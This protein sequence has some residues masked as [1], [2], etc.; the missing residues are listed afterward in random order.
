MRDIRLDEARACH[1]FVTVVSMN[2]IITSRYRDN[3]LVSVNCRYPESIVE[4]YRLY[5]LSFFLQISDQ[6]PSSVVLDIDKFNEDDEHDHQDKDSSTESE[7]EV[8]GGKKHAPTSKLDSMDM[9]K[10]I[11]CYRQIYPD[12]DKLVST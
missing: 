8:E 1:E 2:I 5:E 10:L 12:Y 9:K 11:T 4:T 7:S 3:C 6:L